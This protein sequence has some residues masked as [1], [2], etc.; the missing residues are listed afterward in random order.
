MNSMNLAQKMDQTIIFAP[1]LNNEFSLYIFFHISY[2][3]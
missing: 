1:S 3:I 2:W